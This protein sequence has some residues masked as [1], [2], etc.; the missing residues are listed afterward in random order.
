MAI[1]TSVSL[2]SLQDK[3]VTGKMKLEDMFKFLSEIDSGMELISD[4]MIKGAANASDETLEAWDRLREKYPVDLVCNDIFINTTLYPNRVLTCREGAKLLED[5]IKLAHRLGFKLVRLVSKTPVDMVEMALPCAEKYDVKMALEIHGGM[6]FD[7]P[8]TQEFIDLIHKT[9]SPYLGIV[10]DCGIFCRR[11]P[12]LS[13]EYFISQ[14]ANPEVIKYIDN[15]YNIERDP[16]HY[17]EKHG[18]FPEEL[19]AMF[20]SRWDREYSFRSRGFEFTP[21]EMLDE[22]LPYIFHI[23]G[24]VWEMTEEGKE[25]SIPYDEVIKYLHDKGY[26]GYISTEYEGNRFVPLDREV[27]DI[28]QIKMHQK[29]MKEIIAE[30]EGGSRNV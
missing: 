18:Y 19:E 20:K 21:F 7:H 26:N 1:K 3:Y 16:K 5:E 14:G 30:V 9:K 15:L 2:Y 28:E 29:L 10:V 17:F 4:Q 13:A 27:K 12:R 24:K 23:H 22:H 25:Y 8:M 11:V 6:S